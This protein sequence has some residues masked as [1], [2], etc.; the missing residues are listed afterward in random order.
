MS[1]I[2]YLSNERGHAKAQNGPRGDERGLEE[3]IRLYRCAVCVGRGDAGMLVRILRDNQEWLYCPHCRT[4]FPILVGLAKLYE[5]QA[6]A[7]QAKVAA[8]GP[9]PNML[10]GESEEENYL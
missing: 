6:K 8:A 10:S 1:R 4:R 3:I 7:A 9:Q 2:H 5:Q